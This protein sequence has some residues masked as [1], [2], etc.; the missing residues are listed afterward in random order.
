MSGAIGS[1]SSAIQGVA[2]ALD[3]LDSSIN[4]PIQQSVERLKSALNDLRAGGSAKGPAIKLF[5]TTRPMTLPQLARLLG[6]AIGDLIALNKVLA[7]S[8][9]VPAG[10]RVAYYASAAQLLAGA[11]G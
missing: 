2:D 10:S 6:N 7:E 1:V 3:R 5:T 11:A 4:W 8:P 9:T